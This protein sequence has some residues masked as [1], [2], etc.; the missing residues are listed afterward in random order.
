MEIHNTDISN[1][2]LIDNEMRNVKQF[3]TQPSSAQTSVPFGIVFVTA[4]HQILNFF[5][6]LK[7]SA[8]YT[9]FWCAD[10]KNNF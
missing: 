10:V 2:T 7:L 6:L 8:V 9:S 4:F 5:F 1:V 3:E